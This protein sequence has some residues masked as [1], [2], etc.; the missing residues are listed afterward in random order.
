[1]FPLV[2]EALD[3]AR[4]PA[5]LLSALGGLGLFLFGMRSMTSGLRSLAGDRLHRWLA[6]ITRTPVSGAA[7][8][9]LTTAVIQS[10]SATTVTV[11][12]FV[13]AGLLTFPQALGVIFGANLGTTIT[14]WMVALVGFKLQLG[15]LLL[16][17]IFVGVMLRFFASG[18]IARAGFAIAGFA[19]IF[20]GID[21]LQQAAA[22]YSDFVDMD[23]LP[24]DN[25]P[26]RLKLLL[27]GIVITIITQSSSAGVA[28]ALVA[29][30]AGAINFEQAAALVIGMDVGTTVTAAMATIGGSAGSKRT[31][32]S[33]VIY[34]F[35]TAVGA[36]ILITPFV[37]LWEATVDA[38]ILGN[39]EIALVAFH[40]SFNFL[41]ALLVLPF[42][43]QFASMMQKLIPDAGP[44]YA[45]SLDKALLKEPEI[46]LMAAQ[47]IIVT[48]FLTL[49]VNINLILEQAEHEIRADMPA[50]QSILDETHEFLDQIN[51]RNPESR[52][53]R[54]LIALIHATD[55]M[56]RLHER[57][58]EDLKR[59]VIA[60]QRAELTEV[61]IILD[62]RIDE[63]IDAV[64]AGQFERAK[65][66]SDESYQRTLAMEDPQR[67]KIYQA[68]ARGEIDIRYATENAEALRWL[69]RVSR[70]I[71]RICFYLN[72]AGSK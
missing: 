50:L 2:V 3:C 68:V 39:P 55:H 19:L 32:F 37:Y 5:E 72:I 8:G 65:S 63:V 41:G 26:G 38:R 51:I 29:I 34:N 11:V 62:S 18:R 14:G 30:N 23:L 66:L 56:Q 45:R 40:S 20:V 59:A 70:H 33:H 46:A 24:A 17:L 7:T 42:T 27:L 21:L 1:M 64:E 9:A 53:A 22:Q 4:M 6:R 60:S 15:S 44:R 71:S 25:L 47:K 31:G 69:T 36:L 43:P 58:D 16:P 10:S 13:A 35:F 54:T 52:E 49:M 57:C 28:T 67:E 61:E 12:G 48:E